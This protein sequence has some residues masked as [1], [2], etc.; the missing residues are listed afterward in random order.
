MRSFIILLMVGA[1][2]DGAGNGRQDPARPDASHDDE[3]PVVDAGAVDA[4]IAA[5]ARPEPS[6]IFESAT[7]PSGP[8]DPTPGR[9]AI[10]W[11]PMVGVRVTT[12]RPYTI[13]ALG[14]DIFRSCET[15]TAR[16]MFMAIVPL[17][18]TENLPM[19]LDLSDALGVGFA[20]V[21]YLDSSRTLDTVP[22]TTTFPASFA[23]PAGTWGLIVGSNAFDLPSVEAYLPAD[24]EAT[25]E[26]HYFIYNI[27][28]FRWIH[29]QNDSPDSR[30]FIVGY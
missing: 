15:C 24:V 23:L 6:M 7:R 16:T 9:A 30:F 10:D 18:P 11:Q 26:H 27:D 5:D 21:A 22:Q 29:A 17:D 19:T 1:A 28:S 25:A 4:A 20:E 13:T 8:Y 14:A 3:T 12:S 2:C